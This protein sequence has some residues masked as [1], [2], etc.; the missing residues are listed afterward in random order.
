MEGRPRKL[1]AAGVAILVAGL[2]LGAGFFF[3]TLKD[4]SKEAKYTIRFEKGGDKMI[5]YFSAGV[6]EIWYD[7][8]EVG[9]LSPHIE[10]EESPGTTKYSTAYRYGSDEIDINNRHFEKMGDLVIENEGCYTAVSDSRMVL[11]ITPPLEVGTANSVLAVGVI[12]AMC[13]GV[14][15]L[16]GAFSRFLPPSRPRAPSLYYNQYPPPQPYW[17]PPAAYYPPPAQNE[18]WQPGMHPDQ[19]QWQYPQQN[20]GRNPPRGRDR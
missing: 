7:T 4:P 16:F 14:V 13:G 6:Y 19:R 18:Y 2:V 1:M 10:I 3:G 17:L 12:I 15:A 9:T 11:Y 20:D 5:I 8:S